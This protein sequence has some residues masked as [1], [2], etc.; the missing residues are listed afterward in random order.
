MLVDANLLLYA[1]NSADPRHPPAAEWLTAR[2]N[3]GR[4]VGIAW[5]SLIAFLRIST[6]PRVFPR[7]LDP[8][9]AWRHVED[10]LAV[11]V[12]WAPEPG[13]GHGPLLGELV[14]RHDVRGNLIPDAHLAALALEHG[15]MVCSADTDFARFPEVRWQDPLAAGADLRDSHRKRG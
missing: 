12:V 1:T 8:R 9:D 4:R 10:W 14:T 6:H 13:V 7:P 3:G 11:P 5:T 2:L 15:L